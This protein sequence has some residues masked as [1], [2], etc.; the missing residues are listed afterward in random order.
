LNERQTDIYLSTVHDLWPGNPEPRLHRGRGSGRTRGPEL[1]EWLVL[2]N[3]DSPRIAVPAHNPGAAARAMLRFSAALSG[4][5][6]VKRLGVSTLLRGGARA[7]FPDRISVEERASSLRSHLGDVFGETVDLSLGLGT[8]RT[9]RKPVL[10][11]FD[12]RGRSLAFVKIGATP[13]TETLVLAEVASLERLGAAELPGVLE[14]PRLLHSGRFEGAALLAMTALD[15]SFRQRP[16][17]QYAVPVEEMALF[18]GAF[19]EG[20]RPLVEMPLWAQLVAAQAALQPSEARERLG[21]A[22][23]LLGA[24]AVDHPLAMG[25]WHGDWTPWNMSRRRH[26]LQLWDWERFE[27]GVPLGMDRC[28][29]AVNA[30]CR[31]DGAD[32]ASVMR[33]LDLAG[34]PNDRSTE[35]HVVGA[36]YL[37]TITTRYLPGSE[38]ELGEAIAG[39]SLVMLDALCA[40]LGM[41]ASVRHG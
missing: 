41:P 38:F 20:T 14:V 11:V 22:L 3:A 32:V 21:E 30:V 1:V 29:Y 39:R 9:N 35:A 40:W 16:S 31:R 13:V 34:V 19:G 10:Q 17:R 12:T 36:A 37:A 33:G 25:A 26:R 2:P 23:G 5:D 8:A 24:A 15:T 6:T 18:H 4:P 27:T 28:H 7:A